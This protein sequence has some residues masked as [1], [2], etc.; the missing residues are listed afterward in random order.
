[1]ISAYTDPKGSQCRRVQE[2]VTMGSQSVRA[3]G[4]VCEGQSGAWG[5][6]PTAQR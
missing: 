5:L 2:T 4:D 6:M 1:V 3:W